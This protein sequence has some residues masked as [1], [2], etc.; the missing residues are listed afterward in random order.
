MKNNNENNNENNRVDFGIDT[1]NFAFISL[2]ELPLNSIITVSGLFI[3]K[4]KYGLTPVVIN[5]KGKLLISLPTH[6]YKKVSEILNNSEMVAKIKNNEIVV[7][8]DEYEKGGNRYKTVRFKNIQFLKK[9][10]IQKAKETINEF[11]NVIK[12]A[13]DLATAKSKSQPATT[14]QTTEETEDLPF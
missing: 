11:E 2:R 12:I 13:R 3:F 6:R 5:E 10:E 8:V 1:S 4:G 9:E 7:V 14:E